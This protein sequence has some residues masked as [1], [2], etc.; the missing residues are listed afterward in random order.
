MKILLGLITSIVL[1]NISLSTPVFA[2]QTNGQSIKETDSSLSI[3]LELSE[4]IQRHKL[5]GSPKSA[6]VIPDINSPKAQLLVITHRRC[7]K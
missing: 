3:D 2:Q 6:S 5:T 7:S 4:L 1:V